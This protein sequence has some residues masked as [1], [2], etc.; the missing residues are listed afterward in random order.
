[1]DTQNKK[2]IF[3]PGWFHSVAFYKQKN[4]LDI[5][6]EKDNF[7]KEIEASIVMGHSLGADFAL[8]KYNEGIEKIY[9]FNPVLGKRSYGDLILSWIRHIIFEKIEA[10][11]LGIM[12]RFPTSL[13]NV[14]KLVKAD[15]EK[16]LQNIP[17]EKIVVYHGVGDKYLCDER[18]LNIFRKFG[19]KIIEVEKADHNWSEVF[20]R[21]VGKIINN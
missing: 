21:E 6:I 16:I 9:L 7:A 20:D 13:T 10:D 5:W 19:I 17:A 1:M 18:C 3:I 15:Y 8:M 2:T 4:G 12:L 11:K 14:S